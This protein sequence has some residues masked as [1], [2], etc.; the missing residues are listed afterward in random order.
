MED[1]R[2]VFTRVCN[3]CRRV[4]FSRDCQE[5]HSNWVASTPWISDQ[6]P[7]NVSS[8]VLTAAIKTIEL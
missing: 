3:V 7:C 2:G 8:A 6:H 5:T 4:Q 1:S